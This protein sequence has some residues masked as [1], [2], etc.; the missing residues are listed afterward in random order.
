MLPRLF[1][2]GALLLVG[3]TSPVFVRVDA[4]ADAARTA[5]AAD[6]SYV[7]VVEIPGCRPDDLRVVEA[8]GYL[9]RILGARGY[10]EAASTETAAWVMEARF[11]LSSPIQ[12]T[13]RVQDTVHAPMWN[14][15]TTVR[16][17]VTGPNGQTQAVYSTVAQPSRSDWVDVSREVP[18]T[19]FE[20]SLRLSA[21]VQ[22]AGKAGL[23]AWEVQASL[24]AQENDL[25]A[26]LPYLTAAAASVLGENTGGAQELKFKPDDPR[27]HRQP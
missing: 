12:D 17:V 9:H 25:R 16:T 24:R 3:C 8:A 5:R 23:E 15:E 22:E 27:L 13:R 10:T 1:I 18:I 6:K 11:G 14:R 4:L 19:V 21:R 2:I 26:A 7:L 20:K